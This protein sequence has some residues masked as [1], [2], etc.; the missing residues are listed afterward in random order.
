[1]PPDTEVE[2]YRTLMED[3]RAIFVFGSNLAGRHGA[4]AAKAAMQH[5]GAVYG[6]GLGRRGRSYAIPTK[7]RALRTMPLERIAH[8]V[9]HFLAH[10]ECE[11]GLVFVVTRVGCGLA[12]YTN[13]EIAVLFREAPENVIL[14]P[15]WEVALPFT[16]NWYV[17]TSESIAE[18]MAF[19]SLDRDQA[20]ERMQ[21]PR[22][23]LDALLDADAPVT[24]EIAP[25]LARA[26]G[27]SATFWMNFDT[28]YRRDRA[29]LTG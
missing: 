19:D 14:P 21:V 22:E 16:P 29:R 2:R 6:C 18:R 12:G 11:P 27:G 15:E 5:Y 1:M 23:T 25:A 20:A 7:D 10:A 26:F 8:Y 13:E 24:P 3:P 17:P 28:I 9:Q 4:G